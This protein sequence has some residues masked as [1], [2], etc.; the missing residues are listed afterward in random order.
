MQMFVAGGTLHVDRTLQ[1]SLAAVEECN[2]QIKGFASGDSTE[3]IVM[4]LTFSDYE[5]F[6]GF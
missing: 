2:R 3:V 6:S 4:L 1:S 5:C